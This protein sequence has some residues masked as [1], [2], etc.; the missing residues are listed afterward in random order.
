MKTVAEHRE[1][2]TPQQEIARLEA[3]ARR[4]EDAHTMSGDSWLLDMQQSANKAAIEL[5]AGI[6]VRRNNEMHKLRR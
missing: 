6:L 4:W 5:R 2:V 1:V 3:A